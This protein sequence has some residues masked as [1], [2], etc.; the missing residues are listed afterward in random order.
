MTF[1][2]LWMYSCGPAW[3]NIDRNWKT[4]ST[5][6]TEHNKIAWLQC[7]HLYTGCAKK[8]YSP[9]CRGKSRLHFVEEKVKVNAAYYV[10]SLLPM[11]VD[12]CKRFHLDSYF[13]KTALLH[14]RPVRRRTGWRQ[15]VPTS[16][17]RTNGHQIHPTSTHLTT[18]CRAQCF[19]HFTGS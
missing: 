15:T 3:R 2:S 4:A 1:I 17:Q 18:T 6:W 12:D 11:L 10:G 14:T 8:F 7:I 16:S 5:T 19:S 13:S 9:L